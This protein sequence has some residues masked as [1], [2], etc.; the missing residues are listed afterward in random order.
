MEEN[1]FTEQTA[2]NECKENRLILRRSVRVKTSKGV[3][4]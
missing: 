3:F 1:L 2:M 4:L